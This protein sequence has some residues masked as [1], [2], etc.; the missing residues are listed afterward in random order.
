MPGAGIP[1]E[2]EMLLLE[3]GISTLEVGLAPWRMLRVSSP[4][5]TRYG[6][7]LFPGAKPGRGQ[8]AWTNKSG[9]HL[10]RG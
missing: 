7:A 4:S 9:A 5:G 6:L 8:R 1:R 2:V 10:T 3:R